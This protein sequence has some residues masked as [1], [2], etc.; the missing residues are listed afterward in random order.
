MPDVATTI[1]IDWSKVNGEVPS[2]FKPW[3]Y[4]ANWRDPAVG[5]NRSPEGF[6]GPYKGGANVLFADGSVKFLKDR[7]DARVLKALSTSDGGEPI[8]PGGY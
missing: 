2:G 1:I 3:G 6:G 8:P 5:M 4:P 7:T